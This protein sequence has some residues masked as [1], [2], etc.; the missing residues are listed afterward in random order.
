M[1]IAL[2][3]FLFYCTIGFAQHSMEREF[4]IL[5]KQF[6]TRSILLINEHVQHIKRLKFYQEI[7][8]SKSIYLAKFKKDN[9]WYGIQFKDNGDLDHIQ[10]TIDPVDIP[11]ETYTQ[12]Q[13]YLNNTFSKFKIKRI[14][15][16]YNSKN[17]PVAL[18]FRN[19]FQ[20]LI[21]P[22]VYYEFIITGKKNTHRDQ[23]ELLFDA[24]G[25]LVS[26]RTAPQNYDHILY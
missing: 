12:V 8:S 23:Y 21:L 25:N 3:V 15:Q 11:N 6:P 7:D 9:L 2:S 14:Y 1:R 20:N 13:T 5:K 22:S 17:E 10:I 16:Q 26:T 19:A 4:R 24:E 18:T